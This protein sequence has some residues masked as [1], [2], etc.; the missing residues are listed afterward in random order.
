MLTTSST[1]VTSK[2]LLLNLVGIGDAKQTSVKLNMQG[3]TFSHELR[4]PLTG[5][6]GSVDRVCRKI[7]NIISTSSSHQD[8]LVKIQQQLREIK[9][10]II[11]LNKMITEV[12]DAA[13]SN[14]LYS[15]SNMPLQVTQEKLIAVPCL[16]L[17]KSVL[18][19]L[20]PLKKYSSQLADVET[21]IQGMELSAN[22]LQKLV[23]PICNK[24]G[25]TEQNTTCDPEVTIDEVVRMHAAQIQEKGLECKLDIPQG[26]G[27]ILLDAQSFRQVL[28]N[29]LTNAISST[30]KG[31]ITIAVEIL[32]KIELETTLKISVKDTGEGMSKDVLAKVGEPY[33]Q[34]VAK[35][36]GTGL[37]LFISKKLIADVMKGKF[38]VVSEL[39]QGATFSFTFTAK[40]LVVDSTPPVQ[41]SGKSHSPSREKF[42]R[43]E[44]KGLKVLIAE[45]DTINQKV[46]KSML[47][48]QG[49]ICEVAENGEV[50]VS[51]CLTF[52][53]DIILNE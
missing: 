18:D 2:A 33:F 27:K 11:R 5:L 49:V 9:Q 15:S 20:I 19:I 24:T 17:F 6:K 52:K 51:K 53:P 31:M 34:A 40:R 21:F 47:E 32:N 42:S 46:L 44:L 4:N 36:E 35:S 41:S 1:A 45:D 7:T 38:E 8:D 25:Y 26:I 12:L 50:A 39:N 23:D 3:P 22:H 37:G 16:A 14:A 29:L 30:K 48:D 43:L 28:I 10:E 13:K